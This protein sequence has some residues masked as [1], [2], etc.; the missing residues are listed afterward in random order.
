MKPGAENLIIQS[1][2]RD[3]FTENVPAGTFSF[4]LSVCLIAT[5]CKSNAVK[6]LYKQSSPDGDLFLSLTSL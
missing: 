6:A 4:P 5:M 3:R 1:G 2:T